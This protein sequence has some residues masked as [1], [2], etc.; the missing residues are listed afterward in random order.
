M[1]KR[2]LLKKSGR[3]STSKGIV[4]EQIVFS[5]L[6]DESC[7]SVG[8]DKDY[9]GLFLKRKTTC[10]R[11]QTYISSEIYSRLS[12]VLPVIARGM[13]VP[14]FL[15]NVL[16]HHLKEYGNEIEHLFR[17]KANEIHF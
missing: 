6:K 10:H 9:E 7:S 17:K 16:L 8:R 15:D 12:L 14:D 3:P 11:K 13:S 1:K 4:V 2:P 5:P